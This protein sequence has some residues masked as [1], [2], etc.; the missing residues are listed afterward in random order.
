MSSSYK[1]SLTL[2]KI[3]GAFY[4]VRIHNIFLLV[5]AQ[6]LTSIF[7]LS[8]SE[9]WK[10]IFDK[11]LFLVILCSTIC[12][13]SGFIINDYYDTKKDSINT[14]IKFKLGESIN[15]KTKL[16]LYFFLNLLVVLVSSLISMRAILFFSIYIFF[17]WFYSHKL[18]KL[19]FIGN[20]FYSILTITPFF[21]ILLYF[22][23]I[24]FIIIAYALFLFFILLLKDIVKDM[25]NIKGDFSVNHK[26]IPVVFGESFTKTLVSLLSI[27]NIFLILNLFLNFNSG[28]MCF[29]Y[30]L[31]LAVMIYFM[32]KLYFSKS[33]AQ[34]LFLHNLLR[35]LITAGVF[36]IVLH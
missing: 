11:N 25:K 23:K 18:R 8:S 36:S 19:V 27:I 5:F 7:I 28:L 24:E 32:F 29:Y 14:P 26:T 6:Y 34:Y 3:L 9:S 21:A 31:A 17:I 35:F 10:I 12:I 16:F 15:D 4:V 22:K 13:V 20:L 33:T 2:T 1:N 30:F